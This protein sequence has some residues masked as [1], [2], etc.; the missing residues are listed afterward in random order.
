M[1]KTWPQY[2]Q[3]YTFAGMT[4]DDGETER[5]GFDTDEQRRKTYE[6]KM[7]K[8]KFRQDSYSAFHQSEP[9]TELVET[10][11][12]YAIVDLESE[13]TEEEEATKDIYVL[14]KERKNVGVRGA[15]T[16]NEYLINDVKAVMSKDELTHVEI[17]FADDN[18]VFTSV[19]TDGVCV[20]EQKLFLYDEYQRVIKLQVKETRYNVSL[21][22]ARNLMAVY[23]Y[24]IKFFY[25]YFCIEVCGCKCYSDDRVNAYTCSSAAATLLRKI[26]ICKGDIATERLMKDKNITVDQVYNILIATEKKKLAHSPCIAS[27]TSVEQLPERFFM[28]Y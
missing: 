21:D 16:C 13:D 9:D 17:L 1:A 15:R 26:G 4:D 23:P 7:Q 10:D 22:M 3:S 24:D 19:T 27:V 28:D 5:E 6:R 2:D 8:G 11:V 12:E 25:L 14:F 18:C 20:T